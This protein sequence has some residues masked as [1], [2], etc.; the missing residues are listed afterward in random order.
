MSCPAEHLRDRATI[1][2]L[3]GEVSHARRLS[4]ERPRLFG[5]SDWV[6]TTAALLAA[7]LWLLDAV[8]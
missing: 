1:I 8:R 3:R 5:L 6:W 4:A 7:I 2:S